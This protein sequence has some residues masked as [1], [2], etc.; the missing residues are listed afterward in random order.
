MT[1]T[2]RALYRHKQK[3]VVFVVASV[4][5]C[6]R[7]SVCV[8]SPSVFVS[9]FSRAQLSATSIFLHLGFVPRPLSI[10]GFV[11]GPCQGH[12]PNLKSGAGYR[13][14][15]GGNSGDLRGHVVGTTP[16]MW[17][18][19]HCPCDGRDM[20]HVMGKHKHTYQRHAHEWA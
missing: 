4:C 8:C 6:S 11:C 18:V 10:G 9:A 15:W 12:R 5:L 3:R 20:N 16:L 19:R 17:W 1:K 2:K 14:P 7:P 13:K